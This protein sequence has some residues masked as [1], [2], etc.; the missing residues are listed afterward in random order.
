MKKILEFFNRSKSK[1]V[2][3]EA[4]PEYNYYAEG[5]KACTST[6]V[7]CP[8]LMRDGDLHHIGLGEHVVLCPNTREFTHGD[9]KTLS[10]EGIIE[11]FEALK[12]RSFTV[13][14]YTQNAQY[15]QVPNAI[16]LNRDTDT[17]GKTEKIQVKNSFWC[18][19]Q[20]VDDETMRLVQKILDTWEVKINFADYLKEWRERYTRLANDGKS[21]MMA[22]AALN[23]K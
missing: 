7:H 11:Y 17:K 14:V 23:V 3:T 9:Y 1:S 8:R 13:L 5:P 18:Q 16:M 12:Q 19:P 20:D 22:E 4:A 6:S 21:H 15:V 2:A 10:H